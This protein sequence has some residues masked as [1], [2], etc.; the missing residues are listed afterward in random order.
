[1]KNAYLSCSL[2]A[3]T[4]LRE[5]AK[6]ALSLNQSNIY[7][8]TKGCDQDELIKKSDYFICISP[9]YIQAH[10]QMPSGPFSMIETLKFE[11][12]RM[13][14]GMGIYKEF[15]L[16]RELCSDKKS[17]GLVVIPN[18]EEVK[19]AIRR[20]T[21][22][23]YDAYLI[24]MVKYDNTDNPFNN[25][26]YNDVGHISFHENCLFGMLSKAT[27][28]IPH[29]SSAEVL[30]IILS[31]ITT[32]T[33]QTAIRSKKIKQAK[34]EFLKERNREKQHLFAERYSAG[35]I[36][37]DA[38]AI[39]PER[40][41]AIKDAF[42]NMYSKPL[43]PKECIDFTLEAEDLKSYTAQAIAYQNIMGNPQTSELQKVI[44]SEMFKRILSKY[45]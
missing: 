17:I 12:D 45:K 38:S 4:G 19:G 39:T 18:L 22:V 27:A 28:D 43:V 41:K 37:L 26:D 36:K 24:D 25:V 31:A 15:Q 23:V 16:F 33:I 40:A 34:I 32:S 14:V 29:N 10:A 6:H 20:V 9:P 21:V 3:H 8:F 2:Q 30:N 7:S 5:G 44:F 1:M 35:N 11:P 13:Y 42:D